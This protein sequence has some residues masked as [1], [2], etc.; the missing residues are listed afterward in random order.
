[1][2][3]EKGAQMS[4][5]SSAEK[6]LYLSRIKVQRVRIDIDENRSPSRSNDCTR[7]CKETEW[8]SNDLI[9]GTHPGSQQ[10]EPKSIRARGATDSV[11]CSTE[12]G[13]LALKRLNFFAQNVVLG[14]AHPLDG[15][16]Y[17]FADGGVLSPEI[18]Q[19]DG[20]HPSR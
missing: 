17:F 4:R 19:R 16:E 14:S 12:G 13:Q 20:S 8:C 11:R 18:E 9:S 2:D 5:S 1:M 10:G 6:F 7:G 3:R 15:P